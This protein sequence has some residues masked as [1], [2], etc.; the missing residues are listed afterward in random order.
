MKSVCS[1][2]KSF[3]CVSLN[4]MTL[5]DKKLLSQIEAQIKVFLLIFFHCFKRYKF[6]K[7][8]TNEIDIHRWSNHVRAYVYTCVHVFMCMHKFL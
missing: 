1:D 7:N 5:H 2:K 6:K 4:F 8:S 3:I